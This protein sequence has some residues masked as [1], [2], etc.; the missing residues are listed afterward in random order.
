M[1]LNALLSFVVVLTV[2]AMALSTQ[3]R[4]WTRASDGAKIEG[5]FIRMKDATTAYLR[6]SSGQTVEVPISLLSAEDQA[7]IKEQVAAGEPGGGDGKP[8][9]PAGETTVTLAGAH[10]CCG[11]CR[12][13]VES[14]VSGI[15]G[16]SLDIQNKNIILKGSSGE[17][18]KKG[19]DAIASAGYFGISD[20]EAVKADEFKAD[21]DEKTKDSLTVSGVHLC[22]G[23]CVKAIDDVITAIEGAESHDAKKDGSSFT[24][25][26]K[27]LKPSAV[28]AAL[29]DEGF[30][31]TVK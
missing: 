23:S 22:C 26:G 18:V 13:G 11:G 9:L 30:N 27:D 4:T 8:A 21:D 15:E 16:L 24:I 7:F 2:G 10:L 25:K 31:G 14:A 6:R 19:I 3:A 17:L 20:N 29:R 5:D 12:S 28:L 1:K